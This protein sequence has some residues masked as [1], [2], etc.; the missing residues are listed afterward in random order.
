VDIEYHR[1]WNLQ[2]IMCVRY[3]CGLCVLVHRTLW[4]RWRR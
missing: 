3:T 2:T 4:R 1:E